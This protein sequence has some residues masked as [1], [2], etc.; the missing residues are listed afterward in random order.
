MARSRRGEPPVLPD[1]RRVI[2][3]FS[4]WASSPLWESFTDDYVVDPRSL[5]IS[6]DL[7]RDLLAW[8]GASSRPS[9]RCAP[10]SGPPG[11]GAAELR[12]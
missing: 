11:K 9:P 8:D 3:M 1:G 2:R 10:I 5:G 12:P 7:T 6:D 4:G